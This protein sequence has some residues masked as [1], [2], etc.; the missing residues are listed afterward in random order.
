MARS[1]SPQRPSS[2]I[3]P[4]F[5]RCA[6]CITMLCCPRQSSADLL[7]S[8]FYPGIHVQARRK[9]LTRICVLGPPCF[10]TLASRCPCLP[11]STRPRCLAPL[12]SLRTWNSYPPSSPTHRARRFSD[13]SHKSCSTSALQMHRAQPAVT[14]HYSSIS[15]ILASILASSPQRQGFNVSRHGHLAR[16]TQ[17]GTH[18]VVGQMKSTRTVFGVMAVSRCVYGHCC[19]RLMENDATSDPFPSLVARLFI[20]FPGPMFCT[21]HM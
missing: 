4:R 17:N 19:G 16:T 7:P 9:P 20:C 10:S 13:G 5:K 1:Q 3:I 14:R 2:S 8:W 21:R 6:T 18:K 11:S 15:S 12:S